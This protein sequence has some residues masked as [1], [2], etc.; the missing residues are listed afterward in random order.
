MSFYWVLLDFTGFYWVLLGF[1][2]FWWVLLG[3]TG[4][5]W[6]LLG[7]PCQGGAL[8][9]FSGWRASGGAGWRGRRPR[10]RRRWAGAAWC[11]RP[12]WYCTRWCAAA[13]RRPAAPPPSRCSPKRTWTART[14]SATAA[15]FAARPRL[16]YPHNWLR[17]PTSSPR[18]W[19]P[20]GTFKSLVNSGKSNKLRNKRRGR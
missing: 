5:Y 19:K 13:R 14:S 4:F 8:T 9:G 7:F 18:K 16:P 12:G 17:F 6:V 15:A 1:T 10:R 2:E 11:C 3:F 20:H